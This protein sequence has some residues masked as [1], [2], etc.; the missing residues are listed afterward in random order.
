MSWQRL[1]P[2]APL[3]S[4]LPL[5][6]L[7]GCSVQSSQLP[8]PE[9]SAGQAIHG[10]VHG[11]RQIIAGSHIYLFAAGTGGYGAPST[12][13]LNPAIPG[14]YVDSVGAFVQ[15]A[16]DGSF[17]LGGAYQ[18]SS[19]Q[20][21][22]ILALGGNPGFQGNAGNAALAMMSV[23]GACPASGNFA[24]AVPFINVNEVSTVASV[25]ALSSFMSGTASVSSNPSVASIR[26]LHNAFGN[27]FNLVNIGTGAALNT[28][29]SGGTAP[30]AEIDALA[31]ILV[32]CINS[33]GTTSA[34]ATLFANTRS[35]SGSLP[36]D[37]VG[38]ALGIAQNPG[39]N[40]ATLFSQ[41]GSAPPFQPT[42]ASPPN[43]W[44][45]ALTFSTDHLS[46]PLYPAID[47]I[48]NIWIPG[49]ANNSLTEFDPAGNPLSPDAGFTG[50][51]LNQP[52]SVA[53]D[54]SDNAWVSNFGVT[55]N[56]SVSEFSL[57]G[58]PVT[59]NGFA[60][61]ANC[62]FTA[63]DSAG[64]V[65]LSASGLVTVLTRAGTPA[66]QF[67]TTG[68]NSGIAIDSAGR[69]WTLGTG[70]NLYRLTLPGTIARYNQTVTPASGNDLTAV[71]VDATDNIWFASNK[72][73]ALGKFD[74]NGNLLSPASGYTGAG[75]KGPAGLAID[76][77]GRVWI[78]NRD[79]NSISAFNNDGTPLTPTTGFRSDT[80]SN[81]RGLAIDA[82]GDIWITNFTA[83]SVTEF[84]GLAAPVVTPLN[85]STQGL[86]P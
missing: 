15:T 54:S 79:G 68:F 80:I 23:L 28:T 27:V 14:V 47:S 64:D 3:S 13:L 62:L 49:Y 66:A 52:V 19:G 50:G 20:L 77:L 72:N 1:P 37:T 5:A 40:V 71:A 76:G 78:A 10:R 60:C 8:A 61:G 58:S 17:G 22:Y 82:A 2:V 18:C 42:L 46:G 83:N 34:C 69:G 56:P 67:T 45:V 38:A 30:Q 73:N 41:I 53:I 75:L 24:S 55:G 63:I 6:L 57:S 29:P 43:D 59:S 39:A 7:A 25:F 65:W 35:P 36:T 48:G 86:R 11:G 31:D 84:L 32:P 70:G 12:S 81:P 16:A 44:T 51:G 85:P 9:V 33:T 4:L 74:R 21:V 26:G